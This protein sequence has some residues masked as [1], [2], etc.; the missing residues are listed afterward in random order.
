V[1]L[2][3]RIKRQ[4]GETHG[5]NHVR[6][7][8]GTFLCRHALGF[9]V[10]FW[11]FREESSNAPGL[12]MC[13][14]PGFQLL[15]MLFLN[16][17]LSCTSPFFS[18]DVTHRSLRVPSPRMSPRNLGFCVCAKR[19]TAVDEVGGGRVAAGSSGSSQSGSV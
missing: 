12:R 19:V 2:P 3:V 10:V 13:R 15:E 6:M 14:E 17:T 11:I 16:L 18:M 9:Q 8:R 4:S 5:T 7:Y 1:K